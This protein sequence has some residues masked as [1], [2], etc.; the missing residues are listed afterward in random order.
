[1]EATISN[2]TTISLSIDFVAVSLDSSLSQTFQIDPGQNVLFE[3]YDG[4]GT[5]A[6]PNLGYYD[7]V[8]I[9]NRL[10]DILKVYRRNDTGKN[11]FNIE[12]Y[13]ISSEPSKRFFKYEYLIEN[14]DI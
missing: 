3:V 5:F 11:I 7:S 9:K 8:L 2:A 13:W 6:E 4:Y 12:D 14:E 1:M 10:G